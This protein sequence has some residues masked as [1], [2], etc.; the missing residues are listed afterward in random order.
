MTLLLL[1]AFFGYWF[2]GIQGFLIGAAVGFVL[3]RIAEARLRETLAGTRSQFLDSTFAVMGA[4]C[5]ADGVVT[6]D[7]IRV[8]EEIFV[9]LNL[10]PE[11]KQAAKAAFNRGKASDFDLDAEVDRFLQ[12]A[13]GGIGMFQLF[14]QVQLTAVAADGEVHPAEHAMLV[15]VAR[16]LG[17]SEGDVAR[18]EALLRA[19][20]GAAAS[21]GGPPPA[22][23]LDDAYAALGVTPEASD[24]EIKRA[25]RKLMSE[26]HPDKLT[27]KGL[28][29]GMRQLAE[30][31]AREINVAYDLIR[32]ARGL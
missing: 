32:K 28:P 21:S 3:N 19:A 10:A 22:Q 8:T 31:R 13:R 20:A 5:K 12:S 24:A 27:A 16:R 7:E 9:R 6:R 30:E 2:G 18:L 1:C 11:Q 23:R 14:L 17:L 29:E 25:Y 15:R 26:N 4:L